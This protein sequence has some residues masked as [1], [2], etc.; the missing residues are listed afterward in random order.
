MFPRKT[1]YTFDLNYRVTSKFI[2]DKNKIDII[3]NLNN[4]IVKISSQI[5]E[6]NIEYNQNGLPIKMLFHKNIVIE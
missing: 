3:Y 4:Q 1:G 2:D 6:T 5:G